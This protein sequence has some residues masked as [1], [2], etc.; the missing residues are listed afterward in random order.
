LK[1]AD[2]TKVLDRLDKM[3]SIYKSR[4]YKTSYFPKV[5][6]SKKKEEEFIVEAINV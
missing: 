4:G 5:K 1:A 2:E 6:P 3:I